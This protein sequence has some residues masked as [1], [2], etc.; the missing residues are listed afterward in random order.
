MFVYRV[1]NV[2]TG[3]VYEY[4]SEKQATACRAAYCRAM[5]CLRKMCQDFAIVPEG[6]VL[7]NLPSRK[8]R[9]VARKYLTFSR[10]DPESR[11]AIYSLPLI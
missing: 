6:C 3:E 10:V 11:M 4:S 1:K 2:Y 9:Y 5:S 7:H 8:K